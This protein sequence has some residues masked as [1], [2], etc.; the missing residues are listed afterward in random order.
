MLSAVQA[1][2]MF[3]SELKCWCLLLW[4]LLRVMSLSSDLRGWGHFGTWERL[5]PTPSFPLLRSPP[6]DFSVL[7]HLGRGKEQM[8]SWLCFLILSVNPNEGSAIMIFP[9]AA[10]KLLGA[11]F[12][13]GYGRYSNLHGRSSKS[14]FLNFVWKL[15]EL[16]SRPI[17]P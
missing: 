11:V 15:T 14:L 2:I 13:P 8:K 10:V 5:L 7:H 12:I 16:P 4:D 17:P 1:M 9:Y 6:Y 3:N